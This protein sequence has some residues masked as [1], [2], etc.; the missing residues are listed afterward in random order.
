MKLLVMGATGRCGEQITHKAL[1]NG[2]EVT[3]FVRTASKLSLEIASKVRVSIT[4]S[5]LPFASL[6]PSNTLCQLD[7]RR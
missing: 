6:V 5:H 4:Y 3:V 2:H 1:A 7:N